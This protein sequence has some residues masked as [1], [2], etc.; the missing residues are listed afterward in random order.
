M[1]EL[2][3]FEELSKER[4]KLQAAGDLPEW[5]TTMGWQTF[6]NKY[7]YEADTFEEQIDRIVTTVGKHAPSRAKYFMKR[8]KDMIMDNHAYLATPVLSNTGTARGQSVSCSGGEIPDNIFG[9]GNARTE[10]SVLSQEGFGTSSHLSSI[11]ERG[12][13]ISRGGTASGVL[14][15][16]K[17][18]VTMADNIS[19][20]E[21]RRGAWAGYLDLIHGDF[22]EVA[23]YVKNNPAGANVG[24]NIFDRTIEAL[25][26]GDADVNSRFQRSLLVKAIQGKGYYYFPDKVARAA[27]Q[28]YADLGLR[29]VASNLCTEITLHADEDHSYSCVLSGMV[30]ATYDQWKDTDAVYC[31]T[32]FLDCLISE[33]LEL[34]RNIRGLENIVRGTEKGRAIGLGFSGLHSLFQAKGLPWGSLE[35]HMLNN[36]VFSHIAKESLRASQW[37]AQEWGEP[38]W[39]KGYGVR[40][41]HRTAYAPNVTSSMIFGS[42]SQG[43][44]PWYGNVYTEGSAAGSLFRVNPLFIGLLKKYGQYT[45]EVIQLVLNDSGSCQGLDFLSEHDKEVFRTAFEIDQEDILRLTAGRQPHTCQSQSTNLFFDADEDEAYIAYIHQ[46]AFENEDIH[47]LYYLRSKAGV[48]ASRGACSACES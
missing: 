43:C 36:Q 10:C 34:A 48:Q 46:L 22:W 45:D 44:T 20:G 47:S 3:I 11:R 23:D 26:K 6:K 16:F 18:M 39:C 33:F 7:L 25:N 1:S 27:P 40:N 4:K 31:M 41:T 14:P 13:P 15:V 2:S 12:A 30:G 24:W 32:V 29:S 9:F 35:A 42:E 17:D 38:E 37:M 21:A 28:M 8:W 19:Q 5:F